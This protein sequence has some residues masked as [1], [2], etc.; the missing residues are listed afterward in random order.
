MR[1]IIRVAAGVGLWVFTLPL[2]TLWTGAC[3]IAEAGRRI[4]LDECEVLIDDLLHR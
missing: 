2:M 1:R 4:R 3:A